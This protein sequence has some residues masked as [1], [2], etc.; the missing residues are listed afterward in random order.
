MSVSENST[1]KRNSL[2]NIPNSTNFL[3]C[4]ADDEEICNEYPCA[5][6]RQKRPDTL[7]ISRGH[8]CLI[9]LVFNEI[10]EL[11]VG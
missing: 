9:L 7:R 1:S 4:S 8:M 10:A 11:G 5:I 2:V 6:R 3:K